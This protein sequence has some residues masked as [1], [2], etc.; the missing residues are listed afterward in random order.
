MSTTASPMVDGGVG[1]PARA[2]VPTAIAPMKANATSRYR[3]AI[4][5]FVMKSVISLT[6]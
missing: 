5:L 6:F 2:I 3:K 4:R 1:A